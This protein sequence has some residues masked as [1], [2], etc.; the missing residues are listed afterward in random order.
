MILYTL[1]SDSRIPACRSSGS[2]R[3][4]PHSGWPIDISI[5]FSVVSSESFMRQFVG[6]LCR[7]DNHQILI[8]GRRLN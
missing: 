7:C 2:R 6:S 8:R 4:A 5:S 1:D 3:L